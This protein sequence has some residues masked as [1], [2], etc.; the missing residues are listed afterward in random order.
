MWTFNGEATLAPILKRINHV[1]P[2]EFVNNRFIIDDHSIDST[3]EIATFYGWKV[4]FNNGKGISEGA[5][6]ALGLV[7]TEHFCSFEQDLLLN[8]DWWNKL[9]PL[10]GSA[11]VIQGSR[12]TNNKFIRSLEELQQ[13]KQVAFSL[14]NNIYKAKAIR[15]IGGFPNVCPICVDG[16]LKGIIEASGGSW[17]VNR[18]VVS[19][20]LRKGFIDYLR[21]QRKLFFKCSGLGKYCT[22]Q[23]NLLG[24]LTRFVLSPVRGLQ[25]SFQKRTWQLLFAYPLMRGALFYYAFRSRFQ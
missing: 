12:F 15:D 11:T 8:V 21:S 19:T 6:T 16:N 25:F 1:I 20:H 4:Y 14:D 13:N 17:L 5:N 3:R 9:A 10:I 18:D 2:K 24:L 23:V 7:T 22:G